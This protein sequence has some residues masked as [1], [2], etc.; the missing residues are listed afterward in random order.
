MQALRSQID[1]GDCNKD[2]LLRFLPKKEGLGKSRTHVILNYPIYTSIISFFVFLGCFRSSGRLQT[3][4]LE[5]S[6]A[7]YEYIFLEMKF[8]C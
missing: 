6:A 5:S 4:R 7:V 3:T 1:N 8:A 2:F